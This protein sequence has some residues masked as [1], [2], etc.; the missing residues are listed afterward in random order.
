MN[1][2]TNLIPRENLANR[3][4]PGRRLARFET[5]GK[6]GLEAMCKT[7]RQKNIIVIVAM[8]RFGCITA[9]LRLGVD[10]TRP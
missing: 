4:L 2:R 10:R 8:R 6:S 9:A 3:L 1:P 5:I 7:N